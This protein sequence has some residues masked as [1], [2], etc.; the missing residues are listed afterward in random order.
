MGVPD[1]SNR[2]VRQRRVAGHRRPADRLRALGGTFVGLTALGLIAARS[3]GRD[4]PRRALAL[5]TAAFGLGQIVGPVLA[6]YG[7]DLTGS[8]YPPSLLAVAALLV[9][10]ALALLVARWSPA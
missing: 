6:G 5:L 7:F 2:R 8:F 1:R 3:L 4:N 10:A 9:G